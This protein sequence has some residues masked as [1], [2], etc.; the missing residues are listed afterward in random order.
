MMAD[1]HEGECIYM[2]GQ[3]K[4]GEKNSWNNIIDN[5]IERDLSKIEHAD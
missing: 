2:I 1:T 3:R 5:A 4:Q